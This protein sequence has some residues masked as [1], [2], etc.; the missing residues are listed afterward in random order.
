M[1]APA[2]RH[3]ETPPSV[4]AA[5]C[6]TC[7]QLLALCDGASIVSEEGEMFSVCLKERQTLLWFTAYVLGFFLE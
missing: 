1:F 4:G 6:P 5:A 3:Y 2:G 7:K